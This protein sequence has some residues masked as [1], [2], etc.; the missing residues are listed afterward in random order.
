MIFKKTHVKQQEIK[1]VVAVSYN[2]YN[3]SHCC[4]KRDS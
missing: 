2:C 3:F 4:E 1:E